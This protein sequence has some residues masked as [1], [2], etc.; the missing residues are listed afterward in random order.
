MRHPVILIALILALSG[1]SGA[2]TANPA[3]AA[4]AAY[5]ASATRDGNAALNW[6]EYHAAGCWYRY[7]GT[8][9]TQGYDCSGLVYEAVG[10]ATGI[11]LPRTTYGM[12]SSPR[13]HRIPV[14]GAPRG[15]LLFFGSGHVAINTIW[16]H[17][18]FQALHTGTRI[19]WYKW[20]GYWAPS[21][22]YLIW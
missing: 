9:C 6:A 4:T 12:L 8:S 15:A 21:A 19:G 10:H 17:T 7:G 5:S 2:L 22:A 16:Y 1:V 11:W 18:A 20:S 14:A 13:L 3:G